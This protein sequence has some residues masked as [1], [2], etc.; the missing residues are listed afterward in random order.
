M[1]L[2]QMLSCTIVPGLFLVLAQTANA[3]KS[4]DGKVVSVTEESGSTAGKLVMTDNDG[5]GQHDHAITSSV[6]IT[7]DNKTAKLSDLKKGDSITVTTADDGKVTEL[8]AKDTST[9]SSNRSNPSAKTTDIPDILKDAKLSSDQQAKIK[10]IVGKYDKEYEATWKEF[11]DRYQ[12][13]IRLEASMMAAI[14]DDFNDS[15]RKH[16]SE[17]RRRVGHHHKHHDTKTDAKTD[18][19]TGRDA[20]DDG[21]QEEL[22][23]IG[24]TLSP[25]QQD[26][27]HRVRN[28]YFDKLQSL[29]EDIETLHAQLISLETEK[30]LEIEKVLTK[31]QRAQLRKDHQKLTRRS[32]ETSNKSA[33]K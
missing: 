16:V 33:A 32:D 2:R 19:K 14:E 28:A 18:A 30:L 9:T 21:V 13:T 26:S 3:D 23:I 31:D 5:K 7:R 1:F 20:A 29:D 6:K 25:Q 22:V 24:I 10:E 12:D 27:V 15:Q 17:Q 4:H 11:S 8:A